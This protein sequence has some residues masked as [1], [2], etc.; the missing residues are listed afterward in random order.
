MPKTE[1]L[2]RCR[3]SRRA[4]TLDRTTAMTKSSESQRPK[5]CPIELRRICRP[6]VSFHLSGDLCF[7]NKRCVGFTSIFLGKEDLLFELTRGDVKSIFKILNKRVECTVCRCCRGSTS[8]VKIFSKNGVKFMLRAGEIC[9]FKRD[10]R[11][12]EEWTTS[13]PVIQYS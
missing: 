5:V 7:V 4:T 12:F 3:G 8:P 1:R 6:F 9:N 2:K 11:D 10:L 13:K